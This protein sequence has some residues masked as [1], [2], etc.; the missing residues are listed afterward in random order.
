MRKDVSQVARN[1]GIV[2]ERN[3]QVKVVGSPLPQTEA[4]PGKFVERFH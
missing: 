1:S 2:G 3:K 4:L